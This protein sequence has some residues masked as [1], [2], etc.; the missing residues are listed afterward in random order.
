M[1]TCKHN[2]CK[3]CNKSIV[4]IYKSNFRPIFLFNT[5][6][7]LPD[8]DYYSKYVFLSLYQKNIKPILKDLL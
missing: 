3:T 5:N 8:L 1:I 7:E 6:I 4:F 2:L